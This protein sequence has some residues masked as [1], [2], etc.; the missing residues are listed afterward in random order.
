MKKSLFA[1]LAFSICVS[2][3]SQLSM[4][5]H[6]TGSLADAHIKSSQDLDFKKKM[7]A[8]PGAGFD[9]Q[10]ALSRHLAIRTGA[11]YVQNGITAEVLLDESSNM[12]VKVQNNLHYAQIPVNILYTV[13]IASIQ[14]FAGGGGYVSYGITGKSKETLSYTMTDGGEMTTEESS[15]VF[16]KD[17][18]GKMAFKRADYGIGVMAGLRLGRRLFS[19]VGYQLSLANIDNS[20]EKSTYSNRGLQLTIGYFFK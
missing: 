20:E 1:I 4:G 3:F 9:I 16:K 6:G 14:L 17:E 11:N 2:G 19:N 12:K 7:K 18:E 10:V 15:D 5:L 13:R 8:M